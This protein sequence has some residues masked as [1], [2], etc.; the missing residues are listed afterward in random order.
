MLLYCFASSSSIES[1]AFL[2]LLFDD[3]EK[4]KT[5]SHAPEPGFRLKFGFSSKE[6]STEN[7]ESLSRRYTKDNSS[8]IEEIKELD[9]FIR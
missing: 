6:L 5:A 7:D 8:T 1:S 3:F 2:D 4:P 9:L